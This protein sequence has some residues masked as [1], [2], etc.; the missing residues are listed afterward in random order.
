MNYR[1][2]V[3]RD[4]MLD[5][6]YIPKELVDSGSLYRNNILI[7]KKVKRMFYLIKKQAKKQGYEID[8]MSGY[9]S[10]SYQD[11]IYNKLVHDKGFNYAFRQIAPAGASEHHTVLAFDVCIY[12]S[13]K[14][15][16]EHEIDDFEEIS[17]LIENA[18][19]FGFILRYPYGMEALTGYNYE[20]WHFRYVGNIASY[21][22]Y[23][24]IILENL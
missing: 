4:N 8:I 18:H 15:Y 20:P 11:K 14:C 3:N 1:L 19:R 5:K 24:H 23:N 6:T 10:Y 7:N 9:R 2:L 13:G 22:Y 16:V 12:R 21:M 17:W